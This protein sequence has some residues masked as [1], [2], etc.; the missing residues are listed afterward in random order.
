EIVI[1]DEESIDTLGDVLSDNLVDILGGA[2]ARFA[3]LHIDD[4][5]ERAQERASAA[6]IETAQTPGSPLDARSRENWKGGAGDGREIIHVVVNRLE[7]TL[8]CIAQH[9]IEASFGFACEERDAEIER[10]LEFGRQIGKHR[11]TAGD[12]ESSETD[13][14]AGF[15]EDSREVHGS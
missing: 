1:G 9:L 12:V 5:A 7:I 6:G 15:A 14:D 13:L 10:F 8:K 4:G 11:E 3:A 2:A